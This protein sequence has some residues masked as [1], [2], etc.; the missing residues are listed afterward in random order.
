MLWFLKYFQWHFGR[1]W[2]FRLKFL[3]FWKNDNYI[4][5]HEKRHFFAENRQKI[6]ENWYHNMDS[7]INHKHVSFTWHSIPR[8]AKNC[9]TIWY[10]WLNIWL[11][12]FWVGSRILFFSPLCQCHPSL[13]SPRA[14]LSVFDI[15][16]SPT[17]IFRGQFFKQIFAP[18]EK[19]VPMG[20]VGSSAMM[21]PMHWVCA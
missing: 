13:Q 20:K 12:Y 2:R 19:L 14:T 4:L 16:P 8:R 9:Q 7:R 5:F 6:S 21:V 17:P 18:T 10:Q 15:P 3:L 11:T 1:K